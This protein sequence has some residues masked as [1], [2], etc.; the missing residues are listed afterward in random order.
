MNKTQLFH[1]WY[2]F[3]YYSKSIRYDLQN[4]AIWRIKLLIKRKGVQKIF[5]EHLANNNRKINDKLIYP[6]LSTNINID[7]G[8]E[9]YYN[10]NILSLRNLDT[11]AMG[12]FISEN[13]RKWS[14][15]SYLVTLNGFG[16][17]PVGRCTFT[18]TWSFKVQNVNIIRHWSWR[19]FYRMFC[20][21]DPVCS[22]PSSPNNK[23]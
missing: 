15:L 1:W 4:W 21:F 9:K 20:M 23:I 3:N 5:F 18:S 16:R 11:D 7:I 22:R 17:N 12:F 10:Y 14:G 13:T 8:T 2:T 19:L 6:I